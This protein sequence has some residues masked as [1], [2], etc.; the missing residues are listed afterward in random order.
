MFEI[1]DIVGFGAHAGDDG[2]GGLGGEL[3]HEFEADTAVRAG[4]EVCWHFESIS[5]MSDVEELFSMFVMNV[6]EIVSFV[7]NGVLPRITRSTG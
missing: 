6:V 4:E 3:A 7:G 5:N 2:V 1:G